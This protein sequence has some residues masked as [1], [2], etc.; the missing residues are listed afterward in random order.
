VTYRNWWL[1][2]G[3][4]FSAGLVLVGVMLII[5]RFTFRLEEPPLPGWQVIRPPYDVN[6][7]AES[8]NII[9]AGGKSGLFRLAVG[10]G[11][12]IEEVIHNPPFEHVRALLV[13]D[14]NNT[15]WVGH[16]TGLSQLKDG[17]W[18]T[19]TQ[20]DGLPDNRVNA[21]MID[22]ERRLWVG[23]WSG[24]AIRDG[25]GWRTLTQVDGL[26]EDMVNIMLQDHYG[27]IWFGSYVAPKGGISYLRDGSWQYF[28]IEN[29]LP[30]NNITSLV[31]T[32]D[33]HVWVGTGLLDRGGACQL[34]FSE[35][36]WQIVQV[37]VRDD[38]LAGEKVRSIFQD[39]AGVLWF[40]SEYD[41]VALRSGDTWFRLDITDGISHSEVK[42]ILQDVDG[43]IWLGTRDG[44]TRISSEALMTLYHENY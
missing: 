43:N 21:L 12:L 19:Y 29:G 41:G 5:N 27:G 8:G 35:A 20:E 2:L 14:E 7:L 37:L 6:A 11:D 28:D 17:L 9:W 42:T 39:N 32:I 38:G 13:D 10:N 18:R 31:E 44:L 26:L 16:Q 15:L 22:D 33:G 25:D 23:T 36:G 24:V 4:V 34:T 40:G 3:L 1:P 30:H